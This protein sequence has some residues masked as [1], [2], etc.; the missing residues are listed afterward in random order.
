M[1][2]GS[3][4]MVTAANANCGISASK[5]AMFCAMTLLGSVGCLAQ[6][7]AGEAHSAGFHNKLM[8]SEIR[9]AN[10]E[11]S[12]HKAIGEAIAL[13]QALIENLNKAI[14]CMA[15]ESVATPED[16]PSFEFQSTVALLEQGREIFKRECMG[17]DGVDLE[18]LNE[19]FVYAEHKARLA[20]HIAKQLTWQPNIVS[21]RADLSKL[22]E[23]ARLSTE[24]L[25]TLAS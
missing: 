16:L 24:H 13:C 15:D 7:Y 2:N 19:T 6:A 18:Q 8:A 4:A 23:A 10:Q 25:F 12:L 17:K 5:S 1:R 21:G 20:A 9:S 11:H 3:K 22:P 14:A